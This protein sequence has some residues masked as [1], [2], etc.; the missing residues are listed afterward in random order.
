V[1]VNPN[2]EAPAWVDYHIPHLMNL[3]DLD[4]SV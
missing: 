2:V 4:V 1:L 3:R